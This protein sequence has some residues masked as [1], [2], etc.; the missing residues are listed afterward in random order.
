MQ[1]VGGDYRDGVDG[2]VFQNSPEIGFG[3]G[4]GKLRPQLFGLF[5]F[6]I[7]HPGNLDMTQLPDRLQMHSADKTRSNHRRGPLSHE[8]FV[9][10]IPE[11]RSPVRP[12]PHKTK[13]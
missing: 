1:T 7:G 10:F 3:A 4:D 13:A 11:T 9:S 2:P 8:D 6:R 5:Q 12:I